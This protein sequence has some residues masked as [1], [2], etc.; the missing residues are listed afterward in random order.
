ME[1]DTY[2]TK[3]LRKKLVNILISKGIHNKAVLEAIG[4]VPRHSF[5][6]PAFEEWAYKDV[7]FPIDADQTISQPYTVAIQ[8]TLLDIQKG[9]KILEVGTGSGYQAVILAE[10]GVKVYTIERQRRLFDQTNAQLVKMGYSMIRT[11]YGDGWKGAERFAPFDKIIITAA[12]ADIPQTLLDQLKIG[13]IMV[14]PLGKEEQKMLKITK[15]D[16]NQFTKQEYGT[17]R[18]VP[19]L[20]GVN[21]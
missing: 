16:K 11:L 14:I 18:F 10:L 6:D 3:G 2:R 1:R 12:A 8:T 9:D 7:A 21:E 17:Y 13:G 20:K 4:K 19:M 5:L 15:K